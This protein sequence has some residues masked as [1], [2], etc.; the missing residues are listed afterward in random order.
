MNKQE[1]ENRIKK[2]E[3]IRECAEENLND[4]NIQLRDLREAEKPKLRHGDFGIED[5][6]YPTILLSET[7]DKCLRSIREGF[8]TISSNRIDYNHTY[9]ILGNIFDLLKE[10]SEDLEEFEIQSKNCTKLIIKTFGEEGIQVDISHYT[11][12]LRTLSEAEEFWHK[13]GQLIATLK[14]KSKAG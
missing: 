3:L 7:K 11:A 8:T 1:I 10:W 14:R 4:L 6:N 12:T 5:G 13:L 9:A 2:Y